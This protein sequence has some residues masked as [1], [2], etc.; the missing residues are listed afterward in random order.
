MSHSI[1]AN[2]D[3][4]RSQYRVRIVK[5]SGQERIVYVPAKN[6]TVARQIA[7]RVAANFIH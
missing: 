6:A 4:T 7:A 3:S 1:T 5:E 2:Y